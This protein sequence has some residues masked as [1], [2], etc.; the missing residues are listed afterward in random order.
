MRTA[1]F[2]VFLVA[3]F[4]FLHLELPAQ[5]P[6]SS[7]VIADGNADEWPMNWES[8]EERNFNY[9]I[10]A[11]DQ[12]LYVRIRTA[13]FYTKRKMA[14]FGF[15]LWFDPGGKK[16]KTYGLKFPV[17]GAEADER[18]ATLNKEGSEAG[19]SIGERADF[20]KHADEVLIQ[21]LEVLELIGLADD[22]ITSTRSGITNGIKVA[23]GMDETGT[24]IYE[25]VI[26]FR[27][28]KLNRSAIKEL[29]VCFETGKYA[30]PKQKT[31]TKNAPL[32]AGDLTTSQLSRIQ[33]SQT[34]HGD[35]KLIYATTYWT[36]IQLDK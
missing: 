33:G 12:H 1:R 3:A 4:V 31:T 29:S 24:Y 7:A 14:A 2:S 16:K 22:P 32:A 10:C 34:L 13:E 20:Q 17:G 6:L 35:P 25:V 9:N 11:D 5:C 26:P 30:A 23:I 18:I 19:T 21:G 15:T 8:D 36:K 27:S 28:Y